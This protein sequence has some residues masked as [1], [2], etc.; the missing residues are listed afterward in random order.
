MYLIFDTNPLIWVYHHKGCWNS[1]RCLPQMISHGE[2]CL[3]EGFGREIRGITSP[4]KSLP[5]C[6]G[7]GMTDH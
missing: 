7:D 5:S 1:K 2:R 3:K 6:F 4:D